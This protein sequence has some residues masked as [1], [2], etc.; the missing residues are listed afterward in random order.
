[1]F[2]TIEDT[3]GSVSATCFPRTTSEFGKIVMKDAVVVLKGKAQHRERFGGKNN[4]AAP[5]GE[6]EER[7]VQVELIVD[8]VDQIVPNAMAADARPRE[9]HVRID[10]SARTLLR[11]LK[12][13]LA[14]SEGGSPLYLHVDTGEGEYKIKSKLLIAP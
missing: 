2:V 14:V 11:M 8:R 1:L 7:N 13:T 3:T 9:V 10:G 5:E 12:E 4:G 6:A